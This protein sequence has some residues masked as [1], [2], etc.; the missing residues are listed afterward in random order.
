MLSWGH[1]KLTLFFW[2]SDT[3]QICISVYV[4]KISACEA[5][6]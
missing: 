3:N 5:D 4:G 6:N 2:V 1:P